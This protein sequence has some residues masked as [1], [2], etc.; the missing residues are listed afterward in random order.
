LS[1]QNSFFRSSGRFQRKGRSIIVPGVFISSKARKVFF[2]TILCCS[3]LPGSPRGWPMGHL[4]KT[5]LAAFVSSVNFLTMEM[6]MVGIPLF[7]ISLCI[8]PTDRLQSPQPGVKRTASTPCIFNLWATSGAVSFMRVSIWSPSICPIK[9]KCT[10]A[11][12][13][14]S[15]AC[16]NS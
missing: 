10:S 15:P 13:P 12:L 16:L 6:L 8:S 9:P 3:V 2:S 14:I 5:A 1:G 11:M 7:S 4:R